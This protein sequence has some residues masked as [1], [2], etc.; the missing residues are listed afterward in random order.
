MEPPAT[1]NQPV[2]VD[3]SVLNAPARKKRRLD[4]SEANTLIRPNLFENFSQ[5]VKHP[6]KNGD[7]SKW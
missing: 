7:R 2:V 6:G 3:P 1:P 5:L 4:A